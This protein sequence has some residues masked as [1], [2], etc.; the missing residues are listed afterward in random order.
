MQMLRLMVLLEHCSHL[1]TKTYTY[2]VDGK[3]IVVDGHVAADFKE[4]VD[5]KVV[6]ATEN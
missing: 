1:G 5:A 6:V 2:K 3:N 4:L